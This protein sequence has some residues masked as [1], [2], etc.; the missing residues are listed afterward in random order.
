MW[1]VRERKGFDRIGVIA[2]KSWQLC[3]AVPIDMC[4]LLLFKKASRF[5]F[6]V[7]C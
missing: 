6:I 2:E 5:H 4:S 7:H 3:L 1:R